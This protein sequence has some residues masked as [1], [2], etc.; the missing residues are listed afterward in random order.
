MLLSLV[1]CNPMQ[2]KFGEWFSLRRH[3]KRLSQ[4]AI[5]KILKI[6][7]Q[8]ISNWENDKT[9]PNL[10]PDQFFKLCGLLE[11]T[12]EEIARAFRGELEI[13]D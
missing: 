5:A 13:N 8:T 6:K 3:Q 4:G 2:L 1:L 10:N 9:I 12:T 7:P 11:V